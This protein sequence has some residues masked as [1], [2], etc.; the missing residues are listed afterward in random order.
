M[1]RFL[2]A[3]A[4]L[5][6][7]ASPSAAATKA[8]AMRWETGFQVLSAADLGMTI[9]CL[10]K[11]KGCEEAN[12][13]FGKHPKAWQLIAAKAAFGGLHFVLIDRIANRDPKLA[14]RL[15]QVSVVLQGAVVGL[16]MRVVF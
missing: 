14:L 9:Y 16:N 13:V 3:A 7:I 8:D 10:D 12:P 1:K 2:I 4:A 11:V 5:A 6:A 15:A